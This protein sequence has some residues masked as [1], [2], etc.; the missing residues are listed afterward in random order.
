MKI[1]KVHWRY[2]QL[3]LLVLSLSTTSL[4]SFAI[5]KNPENLALI[6][7]RNLAYPVCLGATALL[8]W[9]LL[10]ANIQDKIFCWLR[11][12]PVSTFGLFILSVTPHLQ[13]AH[14]TKVFNDEP[15]H[16]IRAKIFHET[17]INQIPEVAYK[18]QGSLTEGGW[19]VDSRMYYYSF[20][21]SVL[22]DLFGFREYHGWVVNAIAGLVLM[23]FTFAIGQ[24]LLPGTG[25]WITSLGLFS[26]PLYQDTLTG[27]GYDI[28]NLAAISGLF[29]SFLWLL[30]NYQMPRLLV[31]LSFS[32]I[33]AL[34]R[35]ES[36]V[37]LGITICILAIFEFRRSRDSFPA[38][39]L[40]SPFLAIPSVAALT[41][42]IQS[43]NRISAAVTGVE[44]SSFFQMEKI[45]EHGSS[46][47][48]WLFDFSPAVLSNPMVN[49]FGFLGLA[50][51][52][53][54]V[55]QLKTIKSSMVRQQRIATLIATAVIGILS[56]S[57]GLTHYWNPT[58]GESVRLLLPFCWAC[59]ILCVYSVATFQGSKP[60]SRVLIAIFVFNF[61]VVAVPKITNPVRGTSFSFAQH[62]QWISNWIEEQDNGEILYIT[63]LNTFLI[64][65]GYPAMGLDKA[66]ENPLALLQLQREGYYDSIYSLV[67]ENYDSSRGVWNPPLPAPPLNEKY[68]F[69]EV[70][71]V[72]L[73]YN[74]RVKI[75]K[76]EGW[77]NASGSV[78]RPDDLPTVYSQSSSILEY[79]Q[80]TRSIHPGI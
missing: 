62:A 42:F 49:T 69:T 59:S 53:G 72:R 64:W 14:Q 38:A 50:F 20:W 29:W 3:L 6:F 56:L 66:N 78:I 55:A 17:R 63:Q 5:F 70:S 9:S 1:K 68:V 24:H 32:F 31:V 19:T 8:G 30:G 77:T 4:L 2:P 74:Q 26:L 41:L 52:I 23:G 54:N 15:A 40:L 43:G 76:L 79:L 67:I 75:Q 34:S 37:F 39:L 80:N 48:Q 25:G 44:T 18:L 71:T 35:N 61:L 33:A 13:L 36:A 73:A 46:I 11:L 45:S 22:H 47:L 7:H 58:G 60:F 10:K 65:K 21:V 27:A 57:I 28:V 16:Q 51:L 12:N